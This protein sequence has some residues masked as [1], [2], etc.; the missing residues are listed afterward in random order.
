MVQLKEKEE[1]LRNIESGVTKDPT[2]V[3]QD[4]PETENTQQVRS[5]SLIIKS[6]VAGSAYA[7]RDSIL[8]LAQPHVEEVCVCVCVY[9]YVCVCVCAC[10]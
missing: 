5:V 7:L 10:V 2:G 4:Q 8:E 1:M 3:T 9:V 6:N